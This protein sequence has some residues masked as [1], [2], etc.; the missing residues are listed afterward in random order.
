M[1]ALRPAA[2]SRRS[3]APFRLRRRAGGWGSG[4]GARASAPPAN[5]QRAGGA[6]FVPGEVL[7]ALPAGRRGDDADARPARARRARHGEARRS[8]APRSSRSAAGSSVLGAVAALRRDPSVL[9]AEP[10]FLYHTLAVPNDTLYGRS[11]AC[12]SS[13]RRPPGTYTTGRQQTLVAVIDS[14]IAYDHPD[15]A[16]NMWTNPKDPPDDGDQR[17][18][19][20]RRRRLRL[21]LRA[22]RQQ[23]DGRQ[24]HGT[25][26]AGTIGARGNNA[27]GVTGVNWNAS[28]MA[29]RAGDATGSLTIAAIIDSIAYACSKK[30]RVVNGSFGGGGSSSAEQSVITSPA[31]SQRSSSSPPGTGARRRRRQQ[32]LDPELPVQLPVHADHL[33]RAP[34]TRPTRSRA[35]P[36]SA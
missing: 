31:C 17:P 28:L 29:L 30:A 27:L 20:P 7:V 10:N 3:P 12:R 26:V 16:P 5:V 9:Y 4:R 15:L 8:G 21:G 33:R 34:R 25:H 36:T 6:E 32:R 23:A 1:P 22:E 24:R 14:G 13:R 19:R 18:Q 11:T 35:S 2:S